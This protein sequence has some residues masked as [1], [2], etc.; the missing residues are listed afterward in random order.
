MRERLENSRT[1]N[2]IRMIIFGVIDFFYPPFK[3]FLPLK[4][5]RYGACGGGVALLNL[6]VFWFSINYIVEKNEKIDFGI[7]KMTPYIASFIIA[8]LVS[9][10]IGF[11]LN[12]YI[13]F[14]TSSLRG[15]IQLVR[16][17]SITGLNI[18]LNY[19]LL[20]VLIGIWH[21]WPTPSQALTTVILAVLSYFVQNYF[22]FG[23]HN[24]PEEM[25]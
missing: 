12:K 3:R 20:H 13:V 4:T 17:A 6:F 11:L 23:K 25:Y 19:A 2:K 22:S 16:Y 9:F 14:Q 7:F 8:L 24:K 15:R 21:F 1:L 5:F 18:F 10:P